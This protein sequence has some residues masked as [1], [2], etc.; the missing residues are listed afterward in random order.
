MRKSLLRSPHFGGSVHTYRQLNELHVPRRLSHTYIP[1]FS[2]RGN[3]ILPLRHRLFPQPLICTELEFDS[4]SV[5]VPVMDPEHSTYDLDLSDQTELADPYSPRVCIVGAGISGLRCADI[6]ARH[7]I[8]VT[9]I[10]ARD[11]IGGRV[12]Q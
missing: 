12:C 1:V 5:L 2:P 4:V 7:G 8:K 11:R 10:E 9:I 6:L 3:I